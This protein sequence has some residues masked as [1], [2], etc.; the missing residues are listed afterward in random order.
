MTIRN[1]ALDEMQITD[2][3]AD[4]DG[5]NPGL[6]DGEFMFKADPNGSIAAL[7][8]SQVAGTISLVKYPEQLG[9]LGLHIVMPNMKN[10]GLSEKLLSVIMEY[11]GDLNIGL[12]CREDQISMYEDAGFKSAFKIIHY[13]GESD[14]ELKMGSDI[15]SPFSLD[16]EDL[17][18]Y[19]RNIIPYDRKLFTSHWIN[20]P[21]SLLLCKHLENE[22]H[23]VGLFKPCSKG[24]RLA[25]LL[26][27]D[28][29]SA[30]DLLIS[31]ATHFEKGTPYFLDMPEPNKGGKNLA[32]ELGLKVIGE[33]VRMYNGNEHKVLFENCFS[34]LSMEIG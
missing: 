31:L 19:I 16:F 34:F 11:A 12:N 5:R 14:G 9:F 15:K 1:L 27:S 2:R 7:F 30:K 3:I 6:S 22:F 17:Y 25:P 23:G 29:D 32:K 10:H 28:V 20:Q 8:D 26:S 33:S 24:Y 4:V 18:D 21:Q 13:E